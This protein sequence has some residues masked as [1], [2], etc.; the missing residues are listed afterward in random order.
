MQNV[1]RI[2]DWSQMNWVPEWIWEVEFNLVLYTVILHSQIIQER[3]Q[4]T[5]DHPQNFQKSPIWDVFVNLQ[6][7]VTRTPPRKFFT[8]PPPQIRVGL[9]SKYTDPKQILTYLVFIQVANPSIRLQLSWPEPSEWTSLVERLTWC[10][11]K[12]ARCQFLQRFPV[13]V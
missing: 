12:G 13:A 1:I 11:R 8:G 4:I 6:L 3:S 2:G 10:F 9:E 5:P 7:F